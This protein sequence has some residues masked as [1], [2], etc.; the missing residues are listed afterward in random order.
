MSLILFFLFLLLLASSQ[1][2]RKMSTSKLSTADCVSFWRKK[3]SAICVRV[4]R[5]IL[6]MTNDDGTCVDAA[7]RLEMNS[8]RCFS[9]NSCPVTSW[10]CAEFT[11]IQTCQEIILPRDFISFW[12]HEP[13][14]EAWKEKNP[15]QNPNVVLVC[16][17]FFKLAVLLLLFSL[18]F[19][20][21]M[22]DSWASLGLKT[23]MKSQTNSERIFSL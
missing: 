16:G 5:F 11:L 2:I 23:Q 7:W 17:S 19:Y 3:K 9:L 18:G 8:V 21:E 1:C 10:G 4:K 14:C 20:C 12:T 6:K 22:L 15:P 13:T